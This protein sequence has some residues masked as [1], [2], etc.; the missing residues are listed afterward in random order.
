M[1]NKSPDTVPLTDRFEV[2]SD[3]RTLY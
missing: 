1:A 3:Q 2:V